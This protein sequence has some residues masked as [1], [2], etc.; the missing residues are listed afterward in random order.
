[1]KG[2]KSESD[3]RATKVEAEPKLEQLILDTIMNKY[4]V[5]L[6]ATRWAHELHIQE[7]GSRSVQELIAQGIS[8]I[9]SG[10]VDP[11]KVKELPPLSLLK[12]QKSSPKTILENVTQ[13][14]ENEKKPAE[15]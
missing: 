14:K 3:K 10:K 1:M 4:D 8:D 13:A 11:K 5:V 6:L 12:K 9:L 2:N 15:K 7:P